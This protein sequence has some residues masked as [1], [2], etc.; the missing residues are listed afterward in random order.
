MM[1]SSFLQSCAAT[2]DALPDPNP[3]EGGGGLGPEP[4][5]TVPTWLHTGW[6]NVLKTDPSN[7]TWSDPSGRVAAHSVTSGVASATLNAGVADAD[8]STMAG[9]HY[10]VDVPAELASVDVWLSMLRIKAETATAAS[11]WADGGLAI[12]LL[13]GTS[14]VTSRGW[15]I[16]IGGPN[17]NP[18]KAFVHK[19][20]SW[21]V[22]N[23]SGSVLREMW[24]VTNARGTQEDA[25]YLR[26]GRITTTG[27]RGTGSPISMNFDPLFST[28]MYLHICPFRSDAGAVGTATVA[29]WG[30]ARVSPLNLDLDETGEAP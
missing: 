5:D 19:G 12:L 14:R 8:P 2:D 23:S 29:G 20:T 27:G 28:G 4:T 26:A 15:G 25:H 24:A 21:S 1:L 3:G 9:W 18:G 7:L 17:T 13:N 6:V 10:P 22:T 30:L 11:A 16:A